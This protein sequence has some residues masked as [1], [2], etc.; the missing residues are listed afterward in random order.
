VTIGLGA[1]FDGRGTQFALF[2]SLAERVELCLFDERGKERWIALER[3]EGYVWS[4]Y[5]ADVAPGAHYGYRVHGPWDPV[6]GLFCN[7]NKLLLDPYAR[8]ISGR[9]EWSPALADPKAD[10]APHTMRGVVVRSDFDWGDDRSPDRPWD[11]TVIYEAHVKGLTTRHP[12]VPAE[13]RGTYAGLAHPAVIRHLRELGVTAV[14]LLPVHAFVHDGFLLERGLT[15]YWGYSSIGYFAPHSGYARGDAVVEFRNMV[16]ALHAAGLEV[17]LDVVYNHTAEGNQQGPVLSMRGIDHPA[18][19]RLVADQPAYTMDYTGTG[20]SLDL[21]HPDVLQ[22]VM[23]SLRYWVEEMHVDGFRF[24]LATT[25]GRTAH[26]FDRESAFFAAVQQDPVLRRVKLIAEPWDI[27]EGGYQVGGFPAPWSEWNGKYRDTVR[28]FWRG[29]PAREL[30]LRV[31]GSPDLYRSDRLPRA[32]INFVTAHDGFTLR[33]LVSYDDKH[34]EANG[35]DN[36]D[37]DSHNRSWNCGVEGPTDDPQIT[38]L[39]A[40]QQRNLLTTLLLSRGVPMLLGGDELGRTQFGNNNAYCQ[41]NELSWVD[42]QRVDRGL[43]DFV[44]QLVQ[45]RRE[46][47]VLRPGNWT[48]DITWLSPDGEPIT[49]WET[50]HSAVAV[51]DR[52]RE[53][54]IVLHAHAD[55]RA[56]RLPDPG[57]T[58]SW[59][60]VLDTARGFVAEDER[61]RGSSALAVPGFS[62]WLFRR[63]AG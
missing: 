28:S 39:R 52:E 45:L 54:L 50:A 5:V 48:D 58:A 33:D 12:E 47:P 24:D 32:S 6:N 29:E 30:P 36:R 4:G 42:W 21:R 43:C 62:L 44:R 20:N 14:E 9:V 57:P 2:S 3:G 8:A 40:R 7:P 18:Y 55:E 15:N 60:V 49:D 16:R 17:I 46:H 22:L 11:E 51:L 1:R 10:S 59:R 31:A 56:V 61:Y 19:Y 25:L 27:G 23:D 26:D 41:D 63:A 38:A 37:G 35:E 34:N 53:L 13:Q